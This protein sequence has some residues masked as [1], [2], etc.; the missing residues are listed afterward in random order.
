[1]N[2]KVLMMYCIEKFE[3]DLD[4]LE[5]ARFIQFLNDYWGDHID[6][7]RDAKYAMD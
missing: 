7:H 6:D 1:M 2:A 5:K 3:K 4:E